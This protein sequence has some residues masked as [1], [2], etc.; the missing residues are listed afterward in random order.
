V[1]GAAGGAYAGSQ[2]GKQHAQTSD[3]YRITVLLTDGS[4]QTVTQPGSG[5]LRV[6]DRVHVANGVAQR[7]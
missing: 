6:G 1:I 5:D 7:Y 4:Y 2:I 3:A